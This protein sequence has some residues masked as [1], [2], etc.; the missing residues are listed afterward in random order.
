[1]NP[2]FLYLGFVLPIGLA[3]IFVALTFYWNAKAAR[4]RREIDSMLEENNRIQLNIAEMQSKAVDAMLA[5]SRR[6][7]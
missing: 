3:L 4:I 1:M 6:R 7:T 2:Y 5:R